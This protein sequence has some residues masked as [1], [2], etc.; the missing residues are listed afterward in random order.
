MPI[1]IARI[2]MLLM[3]SFVSFGLFTLLAPDPD[4]KLSD[5]WS[6]LKVLYWGA[7]ISAVIVFVVAPHPVEVF[8]LKD[9]GILMRG[10]YWL[11]MAGGAWLVFT[12][13]W[14][15]LKSVTGHATPAPRNTTPSTVVLPNIRR[16]AFDY[17]DQEGNFNSCEVTAE[18]YRYGNLYVYCHMRRAQS[19]A[20]LV[21]SLICEQMKCWIN[22]YGLKRFIK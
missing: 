19:I 18:R 11:F 7:G 21:M 9:G 17:L 5:R 20:L 15:R 12:A 6:S 13:F 14:E 3:I 10:I 22:R 1:I 2:A 4:G 16:V 8:T